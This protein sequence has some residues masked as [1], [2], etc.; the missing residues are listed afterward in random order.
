MAN[1]QH[2]QLAYDQL[3]ALITPQLG[4]TN[5]FMSSQV[6]AKTLLKE[7][8]DPEEVYL[9]WMLCCFVPWA[10]KKVA[11]SNSATSK[12]PKSVAAATAREGI[13]ADKKLTRIIDEAVL[14]LPDVVMTKGV[15]IDQ[16]DSAAKNISISRELH[17]KAVCQWGPHW[18]STVIFAL[19]VQTA[20]A[21]NQSGASPALFT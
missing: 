7:P 2:W 15:A 4:G 5:S 18:R 9:A 10:Q 3:L 16:S 14:Y 1:T 12:S 6:I 11:T 19:L 21:Q 13:K 20:H 17:G 8:R